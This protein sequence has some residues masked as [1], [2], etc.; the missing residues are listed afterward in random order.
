MIEERLSSKEMAG[1]EA[2]YEKIANIEKLIS[3]REIEI[4][5]PYREFI[6][7]NIGGD[8][9]SDSTTKAQRMVEV[10]EKD[11]YL[12]RL[13]YLRGIKKGL[14]KSMTEQQKEIYEYRWCSK[15]YYDWRMI[16]ELLSPP[17]AQAQMYRKREKILELLAKKE[18]I[19]KNDNI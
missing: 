2:D 12:Q 5:W 6:D 13:Y 10:K 16:G 14:L 15:D 18:G 4:E 1:L 19:L 3:Q 8:R 9:S 17:L 7:E 11:T